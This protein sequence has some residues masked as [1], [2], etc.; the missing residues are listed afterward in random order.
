MNESSLLQCPVTKQENRRK[1][2]YEPQWAVTECSVPARVC[3]CVSPTKDWES[4]PNKSIPFL[5]Q[6]PGLKV[7][8]IQ[9]F[10]YNN[11]LIT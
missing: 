10:N 5:I 2:K 11:F 6:S 8:L 1:I 4:A 7:F 3:H 9:Y